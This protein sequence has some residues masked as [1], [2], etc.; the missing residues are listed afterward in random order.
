MAGVALATSDN[1]A[2]AGIAL[3]TSDNLAVAGG[4][5]RARLLASPVTARLFCS[6]V[7]LRLLVLSYFCHIL[8]MIFINKI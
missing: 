2:V 1:L 6:I 4:H 8:A 5:W 7:R 3:N